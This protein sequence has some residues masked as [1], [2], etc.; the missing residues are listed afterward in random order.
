MHTLTESY[1]MH[2]LHYTKTTCMCTTFFCTLIIT[3][4]A[5]ADAASELVFLQLASTAQSEQLSCIRVLN[6]DSDEV[7]HLL[8]CNC[9]MCNCLVTVFYETVTLLKCLYTCLQAAAVQCHSSEH[10]RCGFY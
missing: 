4:V 3:D 2:T 8:L 6:V 5:Q 7:T 1:G 10:V 9:Q